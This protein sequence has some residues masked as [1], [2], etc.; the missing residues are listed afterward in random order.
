MFKQIAMESFT[1][2]GIGFTVTV[3]L[4]EGPVHEPMMLVG[5]TAYIIEPAVTLL[6]LV[7]D[8]SRM[9]PLE[10]LAPVMLPVLVPSAHV[11]V[12]AIS[13]VPFLPCNEML[14]LVP[15]QIVA[16]VGVT[17]VGVRFTV[18]ASEEVALAA[19]QPLESV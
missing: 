19:L 9:L 17:L 2:K 1:T 18:T 13:A 8:W 16:K 12:L 10:A 4:V 15:L 3:T 11:Y 5:V 14:G 6:G 7:N